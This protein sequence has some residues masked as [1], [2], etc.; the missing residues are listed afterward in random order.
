MLFIVFMQNFNLLCLL[1]VFGLIAISSSG[2]L[3]DKVTV[4]LFSFSGCWQWV[5]WGEE[6]GAA[7]LGD[8]I[9]S[10]IGL[11]RGGKQ[12]LSPSENFT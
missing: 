5:G 3:L 7:L 9:S 2:V 4:G 11:K 10:F 6:G 12:R 8:A 1:I